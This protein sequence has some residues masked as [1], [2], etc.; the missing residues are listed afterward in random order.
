[1]HDP[2]H[3]DDCPVLRNKL[4]IKDA[5]LLNKAEVDITCKAI[6][7]ISVCGVLSRV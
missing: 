6:Y 1:M 3:Y 2:Y 5:E 7:D 4:G